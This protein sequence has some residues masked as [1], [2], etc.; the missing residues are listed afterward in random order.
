[1]GHNDDLILLV[2]YCISWLTDIALYTALW[3]CNILEIIG[4]S[5]SVTDLIL[6]VTCR[7]LCTIFHGSAILPHILGTAV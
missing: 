2:C 5:D 1:M 6:L 4:L 3:I 7:L